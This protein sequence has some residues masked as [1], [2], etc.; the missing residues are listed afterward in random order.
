MA[1]TKISQLTALTTPTWSEEFVYA[2]NNANWKVTLNTVK[3][4]IWSWWA[5]ENAYDAV[6]DASWNGDYLLVSAAIAA[7]KYNIFVKN[8]NYTETAWRDPYTNNVSFL[9]VVWESEGGVKI[10]MP[11]T[12]TTA[13]KK[14]I[15]MRYNDAAD[16]YMENISFDITLTQ[17]NETFYIDHWWTN[18]IVKNC[19][20]VYT[21]NVASPSRSKHTL[22]VTKIVD[23]TVKWMTNN[24]FYGCYF[25]TETTKLISLTED[26]FVARNCKFY[27]LAWRITFS[28]NEE[29]VLYDCYV[30]TY[31]IELGYHPELYNSYV[32]VK[33]DVYYYESWTGDLYKL[34]L[35]RVDNST[36]IL[37]TLQNTPTSIT[38]WFCTNSRLDFWSYDAWW[39][40]NFNQIEAIK[41][42]CKITC[43]QL[44]LANN[45]IWC[46][47][48]ATSLKFN[49]DVR[50]TWNRFRNTLTSV[51]INNNN[52]IIDWNRFDGIGT[53]TITWNYNVFTWNQLKNMTFSDTWTWTEKS[54]NITA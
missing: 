23:E 4:F 24:W 8:W 39:S 48:E 45:T 52:Q 37:W 16:F 53:L 28:K 38:L 19:S 22:F 34:Y 44:A 5:V 33:W 32:E 20:F 42:C 1:N 12:M 7:G 26:E 15:D 30:D 21:T 3:S 25:N 6:V 10:T 46:E 41:S 27:S 17:D 31:G 29:P 54:N 49:W 40:N 9:R 2:Y 13:N 51:T 35:W 18:F 47:I 14:M 50:V 36:V 11:S 43:W